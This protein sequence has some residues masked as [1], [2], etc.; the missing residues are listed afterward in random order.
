ML[1][2]VT[3]NIMLAGVG[4]I[5]AAVLVRVCDVSLALIP[6]LLIPFLVVVGAVVGYL[7]W[8]RPGDRAMAELGA[9]W[10]P[11][12]VTADEF[13]E[14]ALTPLSDTTA[15]TMHPRVTEPSWAVMLG[16]VDDRAAAA[17]AK[18]LADP[19]WWAKEHCPATAQLLTLFAP[20]PSKPVSWD[21]WRS[22]SPAPPK[23]R[24]VM[25][26][27]IPACIE[28]LIALSR[29]ME[30][31]AEGDDS[32]AGDQRAAALHAEFE[33][34]NAQRQ[35]LERA[36]TRGTTICCP[37]CGRDY[38]LYAP[39]DG[40]HW[41]NP[42][43]HTMLTPKRLSRCVSGRVFLLT[44][45]GVLVERTDE[46]RK[47]PCPLC[48]APIGV[49][50]NRIETPSFH[51][52]V[53]GWVVACLA[54]DSVERGRFR[55]DPTTGA[56]TVLGNPDMC[57]DPT[58]TAMFDPETGEEIGRVRIHRGRGEVCPVDA[59]RHLR[60]AVRNDAPLILASDAVTYT[61]IQ[62]GDI[63]MAMVPRLRRATLYGP[64]KG[65]VQ[66]T[67]EAMRAAGFPEFAIAQA[68]AQLLAEGP[69]DFDG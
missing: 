15:D 6:I 47:V 60:D 59:R 51:R 57:P 30:L 43:G 28:R 64:A 18:D 38:T 23:P 36:Q 63:G 65:A 46:H 11:A 66:A 33:A 27:T 14:R 12:T 35:H 45:E 48:S 41:V 29:E 22:L 69:G 39:G 49:S 8:G 3:R 42:Q 2:H 1:P 5:I 62:P 16:E 19:A 25:P 68:V 26:A 20:A 13:L 37:G 34:V 24:R 56:A 10:N 32:V 17:A 4:A 55:I 9:R 44:K 52:A 31:L 7:R 50:R 58:C 21:V 53:K 61:R 54:G 67:A 40:T